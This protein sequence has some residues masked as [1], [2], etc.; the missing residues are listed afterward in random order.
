VN[1]DQRRDL[2]VVGASA[3]GVNALEVLA[4]GIPPDF[5][6]VIAIVLHLSPSHESLLPHILSRA[7]LRN[8][9]G[10]TDRAPVAGGSVYVAPP[11]R[12]LVFQNGSVRVTRGPRENCH[13]PSIDVMFRSAAANYGP[14]VV[15]VLLSGA[16]DDGSEA[17]RQIRD[18]GGTTIVQDPADALFP[19]MPESAL[20]VVEPDYLLPVSEIGPVI[21]KLA[22]C[23][24]NRKENT[25]PECNPSPD[26]EHE[27]GKPSNLI[28]PDCGGALW[29]LDE[30]SLLRYRCR[31]GHA[32]STG[33]MM[34]ASQD[35][36][37][38]SLWAAVR[39]LEESADLSRRVGRKTGVLRDRMEA[40]AAEQEEHAR[41]IQEILTKG[42]ADHE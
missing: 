35:A 16:D 32:Y 36:V 14:R 12:H 9:A 27:L 31:V 40:K 25:M 17:L 37:E 28:C 34:S 11:D 8:A 15:G 21:G 6:G 10:A 29:E 20:Q 23:P 39:S 41:T 5:A 19:V 18:C 3:G 2:V 22:T 24:A 4:S 30:G 38:R 33:S 42:A 13:R 7:G 1:Q 26:R